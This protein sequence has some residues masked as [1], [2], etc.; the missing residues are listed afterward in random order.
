MNKLFEVAIE[1]DARG[2]AHPHYA[3][4]TAVSA[5]WAANAAE[6]EQKARSDLLDS[7][8]VPLA[9]PARVGELNPL[10]WDNHLQHN[11]AGMR[12]LLPDQASVIAAG[13]QA[14]PAPIAIAF[15]PH[16]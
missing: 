3:Q 10:Q 14:D 15:Y 8:H 12:A 7:G 6:A 16:D 11:W 1:V 4:A 2:Q 9:L 5:V 13:E